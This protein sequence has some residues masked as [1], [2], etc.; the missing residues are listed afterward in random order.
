MALGESIMRLIVSAEVREAI[1]GLK[2]VSAEA[3]NTAGSIAAVAPASNEA[4]GALNKVTA[5]V[6]QLKQIAQGALA[7]LA[8]SG[9]AVALVALGAIVYDAIENFSKL[10]KAQQQVNDALSK[11]IGASA[12]EVQ[13]IKNLV[14]II[15]DE[16]Q[17]RSTRLQAFKDLKEEYPNAFKNMSLENTSLKDLQGATDR[18]TDAL[19]RQAKIKALLSEL[20]NIA[21]AQNKAAVNTS[22]SQFTVFDKIQLAFAQIIGGV[23]GT[24]NKI[25][26]LK[27]D[28]LKDLQAEADL[29]NKQIKEL[30]LTSE[31]LGDSNL[32]G[33]GKKDTSSL[34]IGKAELAQLQEIL[35]VQNEIAKPSKEPLFKQEALSTNTSEVELI[36][37]KISEAIEQGNKIGTDNSRRYAALLADLY[38]QELKK[39]RFPD[40]HTHIAPDLAEVGPDVDKS[41]KKFYDDTGKTLDERVKKLPPITTDIKIRPL[42]TSDTRALAKQI[43][44]I[45]K[46]ITEAIKG[47]L[48]SLGESIGNAI[49][50]G[51]NVLEAAGKSILATFGDLISN[52]GKALIEYGLI[53]EGLDKIFEGGFAIPGVAAIALGVAAIAL[54]SLIKS[55]GS[56][57][58]AMAEGGVVTGPQLALIGEA[59]PEVVFPLDKLNQ[60]IKNKETSTNVNVGGQMKI[61]GTDLVTILNRANKNRGLI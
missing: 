6:G 49:G 26:E 34:D 10:E 36:Q 3:K 12:G 44:D 45:N 53:K 47:G 22:L 15:G 8:I 28:K 32:L 54:G 23:S 27:T 37:H 29:V 58:K 60:F 11:G 16:T 20:G 4:T 46:A 9:A 25:A 52:I 48:G 5:S 21:E 33:K 55:V 13:S 43:Q 18:L 40:L 61:Q 50:N 38:N 41:I 39:V 56:S 17:A 7:G 42:I 59:G 57:Y 14:S 19:I 30:Q 2:A 35:R 24:A 51:T 31:K 1:I